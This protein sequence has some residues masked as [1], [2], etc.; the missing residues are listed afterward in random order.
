MPL[1]PLPKKKFSI[2]KPLLIILGIIVIVNP[3]VLLIPV[4]LFQF[5]ISIPEKI[6]YVQMD[7]EVRQT[8]DIV[9]ADVTCESIK[10]VV[11]QSDKAIDGTSRAL[12]DPIVP[13]RV[14]YIYTLSA[15]RDGELIFDLPNHGRVG[16]QKFV[17]DRYLPFTYKDRSTYHVINN[18]EFLKLEKKSP[19]HEGT[20]ISVYS[21]SNGVDDKLIEDIAICYKSNASLLDQAWQKQLAAFVNIKL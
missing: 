12:G 6:N 3:L 18:A 7:K 19:Y 17:I 15:Y 14:T 11:L 20:V 1:T 2:P 21:D 16:Q 10:L 8:P 4:G 13:S 5:T 9:L